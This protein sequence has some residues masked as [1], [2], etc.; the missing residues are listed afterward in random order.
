[1]IAALCARRMIL[2]WY[3]Y[4]PK[5]HAESM[6]E[7]GCVKLGILSGYQDVE[8]HGEAVGD[9][10][11]N[12]RTIYSHDEHVKTDPKQLNPLERQF[13]DFGNAEIENFHF[14]NNRIEI[15]N[16]DNDLLAYCTSRPFNINAMRKMS[17]ENIKAG[18]DAYDACVE[19]TDHIGFMQALCDFLENEHGIIYKGHGDCFYRERL[20]HWTQAHNTAAWNIKDKKYSYQKECR[21]VFT[22]PSS[23]SEKSLIVNV[24][25]IK[26]FCRLYDLSA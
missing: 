22:P 12:T 1:M 18:N 13:F 6:V 10:D 3:K 9:P 26:K 24:P 2:Q 15:K 7:D 21:I 19:I 8:A 5:I 4:L 16:H 14:S 20:I 17:E 23:F 11:E 25:E